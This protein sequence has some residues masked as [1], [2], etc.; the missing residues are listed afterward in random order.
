MEWLFYVLLV[1]AGLIAGAINTLAGGGS[2]LTLPALM[3]LGLPADIA[4]AT[5]RVAV[6]AQSLAGASGFFQADRLDL[7]QFWPIVLPT[8]W[9]GLLGAIAASWCPVEWLK[10]LLLGTMLAMA[11]LMLVK[12]E[13]IA[14]VDPTETPRA[15]DTPRARWALVLAGFYGGFVQAG[16]GFVLLAAIAG[17]LRYDLVRAN[18]FKLVCTGAF[19][20]VA[21]G[22]FI[23]RG[24]VQWLPGLALALG[25]VFGAR[26]SVRLALALPPERLRHLL[27]VLV[28]LMSVAAWWQ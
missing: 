19:T 18:G 27:F 26:Y 25:S 28:V 6:M 14:P 23:A 16:V 2:M 7:Q 5:N 12:P 20:L 10:P 21:L 15:P 3:L 9:G 24:Q 8:L 22:V 4:N 1:V 17:V 13:M 11:L